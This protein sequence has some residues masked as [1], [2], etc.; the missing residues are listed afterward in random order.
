MNS[1]DPY[2]ITYQRQRFRNSDRGEEEL[3]DIEL[4]DREYQFGKGKETIG[5]DDKTNLNSHISSIKE[6]TTGKKEMMSTFRK[7]TEK[8]GPTPHSPLFPNSDRV[9]TISG[10]S[11]YIPTCRAIPIYTSLSDL[12]CLNS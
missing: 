1:E 10:R 4:G 5:D 6:L 9:S 2:N 12:P 3:E 8:N 7:I 11:T